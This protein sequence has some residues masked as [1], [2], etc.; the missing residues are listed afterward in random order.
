[1]AASFLNH[2]DLSDLEVPLGARATIRLLVRANRAVAHPALGIQLFDR[3]GN[4]IF[5]A[6]TPQ[7]N[8][9]LSALVAG[10]EIMLDFRLGFDVQPGEYTLGLDAA[11]IGTDGP[12]IGYFQDR[13]TGVGPIT[14]TFD[15]R[16]PFPFFGAARLPLE[17]SHA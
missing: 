11:E 12:N 17:I 2:L 10:E 5:S 4:L 14:V 13:I 15:P 6:G 1:M 7:L 3:M 8:F 9:P 16:V